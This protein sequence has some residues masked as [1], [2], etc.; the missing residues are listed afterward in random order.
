[1]CVFVIILLFVEILK[2][3]SNNRRNHKVNDVAL[4]YWGWLVA[5]DAFV[6]VICCLRSGAFYKCI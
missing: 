6:P 1:V 5:Y 4:I 2:T 3:K